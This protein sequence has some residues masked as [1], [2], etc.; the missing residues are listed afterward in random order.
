M[1]P[2][3]ASPFEKRIRNP[4]ACCDRPVLPIVAL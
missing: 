1:P 2:S 4:A 3:V